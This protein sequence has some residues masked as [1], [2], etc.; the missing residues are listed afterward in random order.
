MAK[1]NT[2]FPNSWLNLV[3]SPT[4]NRSIK[5]PFTWIKQLK[6]KALLFSMY[7]LN[8]FCCRLGFGTKPPCFFFRSQ[9]PKCS[10]NLGKQVRKA[11][12]SWRPGR[13]ELDIFLVKDP[14]T[15]DPLDHRRYSINEAYPVNGIYL[16]VPSKFM[17]S[18][19]VSTYTNDAWYGISL[20][21]TTTIKIN[22][23]FPN[24]DDF[25]TLRVHQWWLY[26]NTQV[27]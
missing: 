1:E 10:F 26:E 15:T 13:F 27:F 24:F 9:M 4:V 3:I 8:H 6:L 17:N 16:D 19:N 7:F 11:G 12:G 22:V 14:P 18:W 21:E 25:S 2:N 23:F 5:Q 20:G